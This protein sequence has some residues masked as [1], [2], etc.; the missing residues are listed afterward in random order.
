MQGVEYTVEKDRAAN[1]K[2]FLLQ[3]QNTTELTS[4]AVSFRVASGVVYNGEIPLVS[5]QVVVLNNSQRALLAGIARPD[6][7]GR[8]RTM[9]AIL[10]NLDTARISKIPIADIDLE[11]S[12]GSQMVMTSDTQQLL[13]KSLLAS[14]WDN[15]ILESRLNALEAKAQAI[16]N[17]ES[18]IHKLE[19][20]QSQQSLALQK[21][22]Q[23][24][25]SLSNN[26]QSASQPGKSQSP[27]K[28]TR[29]TNATGT[30]TSTSKN[31][32][33]A[34]TIVSRKKKAESSPEVYDSDSPADEA[35][36][37]RNPEQLLHQ[38]E[39]EE[40]DLKRK[41]KVTLDYLSLFGK[42]A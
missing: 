35:S 20:M 4:K 31:K 16:P 17:L 23:H 14:W 29:A 19:L 40:H 9:S 36:P 26:T 28:V 6:G 21:L 41:K 11:A 10:I 12:S 25:P 24:T 7:I 2:H 34:D 32:C 3:A 37:A 30:T 8:N 33:K 5:G 22:L 42:H 18:S 27:T 1:R 38:L 13:I 15:L 39:A